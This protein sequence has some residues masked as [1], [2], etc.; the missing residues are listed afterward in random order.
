MGVGSAFLATRQI[1]PDEVVLGHRA[2]LVLHTDP[3]SS[4]PASWAGC[5]PR[6]RA[7][8]G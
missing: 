7:R 6:T 5:S 4:S 1:L 3:A 2:L 8:R